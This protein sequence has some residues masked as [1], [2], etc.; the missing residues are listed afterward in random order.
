M[1]NDLFHWLISVH[2]TASPASRVTGRSLDENWTLHS[3]SIPITK[4]MFERSIQSARGFYIQIFSTFDH[5]CLL[6]GFMKEWAF[7]H[8]KHITRFHSFHWSRMML[9]FFF[10]RKFHL[11]SVRGLC[12]WESASDARFRSRYSINNSL[13]LLNYSISGIYHAYSAYTAL[14]ICAQASDS[15]QLS[16][17]NFP[18]CWTNVRAK[19][20]YYSDE[21]ETL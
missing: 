20:S 18:N 3:T 19:N 7:A 9:F 21:A 15:Q 14:A 11:A 1:P 8:R 17:I 6:S 16:C 12:A 2:R 5:K 4:F 13:Y 10:F